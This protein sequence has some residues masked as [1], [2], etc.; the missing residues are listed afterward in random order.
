MLAESCS[1][2]PRSNVIAA[3]P[4]KSAIEVCAVHITGTLQRIASRTGRPN[5]SYTAGKTKALVHADRQGLLNFATRMRHWPGEVRL[6]H[7][8]REAKQQLAAALRARYAARKLP[9]K[10]RT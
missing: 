9:V 8:E 10:V 5:P 1:L 4:A 2:H 6:V 3:S 7:G